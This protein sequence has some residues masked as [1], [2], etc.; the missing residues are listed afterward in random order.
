LS[1]TTVRPAPAHRVASA[2]RPTN[3][4]GSPGRLVVHLL[5]Q[6]GRIPWLYRT[7][8]PRRVRAGRV[9]VPSVGGPSYA[10]AQPAHNGDNH[11]LAGGH[12]DDERRELH[13]I[14]WVFG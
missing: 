11:L 6:L 14:R 9:V 12:T 1:T 8:H 13:R 5:R 7:P 3:R 4:F 10:R 2:V